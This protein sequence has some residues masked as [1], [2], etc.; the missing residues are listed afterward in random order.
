MWVLIGLQDKQWR[1]ESAGPRI[2]KPK[3]V[4]IDVPPSTAMIIDN[5]HKNFAPHVRAQIDDHASHRLAV[6]A[7]DFVKDV[8]GVLADQFHPSLLVIASVAQKRRERLGDQE[9]F[10]CQCSGPR[11]A[12]LFEGTD[13][14]F[15]CVVAF[16][17]RS[18]WRHRV[19]FDGLSVERVARLFCDA[20]GRRAEIDD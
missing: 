7:V 4:E 20:I 16:H 3:M 6:V 13:P 11:V 1:S 10:R 2:V 14:E 17:A 9:W 18:S 15:A 19:A 12:M 5:P 8:A